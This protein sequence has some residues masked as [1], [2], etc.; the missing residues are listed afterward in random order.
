MFDGS[1]EKRVRDNGWDHR[2]F[3]AGATSCLGR[4]VIEYLVAE[5]V[6][7]Y[8][9]I[10]PDQKHIDAW[11]EYFV[12]MG[13][14]PDL[15]P[16]EQKDMSKYLTKLCPSLVLSFLGSNR[17]RMKKTGHTKPNPFED[18]YQAVDYGLTAMTIRAA[19][20]ATSQPRVI[21][22]SA[23]GSHK[24]GFSRFHKRKWQLEEFT[25]SSKLPYTIIRSPKITG[26]ERT[27]LLDNDHRKIIWKDVLVDTLSVRKIANKYHSIDNDYLAEVVADIALDPSTLNSIISPE[28]YR[29]V[30]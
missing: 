3:I 30:E 13:A 1:D 9:H 14:T 7:T 2:A 20:S 18:S 16:W 28:E 21:I 25:K 26:Q 29:I 12:S 17:D 19:T 23:V 8:A 6:E 5:G 27:D 24:H 11:V 15:T 22:M 10:R 4:K